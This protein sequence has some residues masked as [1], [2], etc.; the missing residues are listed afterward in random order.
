MSLIR[1]VSNITKVILLL[2]FLLV[3]YMLYVLMSS[4]YRS[5]QIDQHIAQFEKENEKIADENQ[6]LGDDFLYYT[7]PQYR[8]K[9]AKQNLG[10]VNAGEKVI[11]LPEDDTV[12]VSAVEKQAEDSKRR[13]DTYTNL[14]KWWIFFFDRERFRR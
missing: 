9:I 12:V 10:L 7:S 11:I 2:E 1:P 3:S 5:Y 4:I 14:Q 6:R 8:D 13:W